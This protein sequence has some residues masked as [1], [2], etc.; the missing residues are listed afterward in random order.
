M[1]KIKKKK[2]KLPKKTTGNFYYVV[3]FK[4]RFGTWH[5]H[6]SPCASKFLSHARGLYRCGWWMDNNSATEQ[7]I[8]RRYDFVNEV[9][10][11]IDK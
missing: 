4:D 2:F 3:Q 10:K 6:N 5:D 1:L 9:K 7:R 8:V 11:T